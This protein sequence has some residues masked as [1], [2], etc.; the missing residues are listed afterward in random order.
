MEANLDE[1]KSVAVH[2]VVPKEDAVP[3]TQK[4]RMFRMR[5]RAKPVGINGI[6]D[7]ELKEQLRL[8]SE[9]IRQDLQEGSRVGVR[10]TNSKDFH[11]ISENERQDIVEGWPPPR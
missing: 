8:G 6:R 11:K 4:G 1:M 10:K 5:H 2:E 7:R 9:T 3:R